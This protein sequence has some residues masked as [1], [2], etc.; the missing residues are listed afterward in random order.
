MADTHQHPHTAHAAHGRDMGAAF[1][2]LVIG[3]IVL[4][5]IVGTVVTL[6]NRHFANER[7]AAGAQH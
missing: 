2:G 4:L 1:I 6:T 7:P 5:A 3:M